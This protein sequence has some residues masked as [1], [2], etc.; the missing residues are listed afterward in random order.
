MAPLILCIVFTCVGCLFLT[1]F[2]IEKVK[3]YTVKATLL[4][5]IASLF[6]IAT[7]A[8]G[9]FE[10]GHHYLSLF[11]L[12]GLLLGLLGDIWL[13]FKYVFKQ[14][15]RPFTYAG[16][17]VFGLG[18]VLYI[19]GMYLEFYRGDNPLYIILPLVIG[20]S[21]SGVNLLLE[22]P[23]KLK[24]GEY[25]FI[26]FAYGVCLFSFIACSFSL[27]LYCNF[28][29]VTMWMIFIASIFFALSDLI[30]SGTF[31][32]VGKERPFDIVSN[33]ITYYIAQYLIAFSMIFLG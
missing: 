26:V 25:R 33:G 23:M 7:C 28:Q 18:H 17:I 16:F 5:T 32:G 21:I 13:D 31:F 29:D 30:L 2:L 9:L 15:E 11:A 24:F 10:R 14:H 27:L 20:A 19:T 6:F 4:K 3:A 22:K 8:V 1:L 12:L